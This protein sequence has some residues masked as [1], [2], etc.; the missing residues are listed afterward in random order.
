MVKMPEENHHL[1]QQENEIQGT[2][3]CQIDIN[4]KI[5]KQIIKHSIWIRSFTFFY[6]SLRGRCEENPFQICICDKIG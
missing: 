6:Q 4:I 2:T 1:P 5:V 3:D